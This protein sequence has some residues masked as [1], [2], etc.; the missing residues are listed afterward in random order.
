MGA[1]LRVSITWHANKRIN[2]RDANHRLIT[3]VMHQLPYQEG[4]RGIWVPK[5]IDLRVIYKDE[6]MM[7]KVVTVTRKNGK[8][9]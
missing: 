7:R 1:P 3:R 4:V 8:D 9:W 2:Q 6:H 5:G